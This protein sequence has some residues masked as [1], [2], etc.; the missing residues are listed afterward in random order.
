[1]SLPS[2]FPSNAGPARDAAIL[3]AVSAGQVEYT[4]S[5]VRTSYGDH[6]AVFQVFSDGLKL[7]GVRLA[8]SATLCQQ[9]A[10]SLN[11]C[12]ATPRLLDEAWIQANV[13]IP[14]ATLPVSADTATMVLHSTTID[15]YAGAASGAQGLVMPIGKPWVLAKGSTSD[16]ASLY[17]WQSSRPV[18]NVKLYSSPATPGVRVIQ[19]L[20]QAHA[21]DYVDYSSSIWLVSR[22]C[23]VDGILRDLTEVLRD[24]SLAPLASHEGALVNVRQP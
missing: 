10:D 23:T 2:D 16:R 1:M 8:G 11:C 5:P 18:G 9:V 14:P 17:G 6:T 24:A 19:P 15:G 12:L 4:W 3:A 7:G 21:P 13:Q 22:N 20:S